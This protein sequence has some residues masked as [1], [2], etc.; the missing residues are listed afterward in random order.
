MNIVCMSYLHLLIVL[1]CTGEHPC[2]ART[3]MQKKSPHHTLVR[4]VSGGE[5]GTWAAF[6]RQLSP[7]A[8]PVR[9]SP[10]MRRIVVLFIL[11]IGALSFHIIEP[12]PIALASMHSA[13]L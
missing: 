9:A 12:A 4:R 6:S 3:C 7:L 1:S 10:K 2:F 11:V 13:L 5:G 8:V